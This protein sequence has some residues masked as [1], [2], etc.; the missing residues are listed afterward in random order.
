[1]LYVSLGTA[2]NERPHFYRACL[3]AFGDG[4]WPVAMAVGKRVRVEDLG[5]IPGNVDA[6]PLFPLPAVLR[7][8][9]AFVSHAGMGSTME[10]LYYGVPLVCAANDRAGHQRARVAEL[11]HG[12]RLD[13]ATRHAAELR[14]AVDRVTADADCASRS[15][16]R[17]PRSG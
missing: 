17:G 9:S 14:A 1:V 7:S 2:F 12:V 13:P 3:K 11:G 15:T 10:A 16:A 5:P 4:A 6:R 8:A